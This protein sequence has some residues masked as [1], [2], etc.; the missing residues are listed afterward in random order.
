MHA[1]GAETGMEPL[2]PESDVK[3]AAE[4]HVFAVYCYSILII[5]CRADI[6]VGNAI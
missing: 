6:T 2:L 1:S 5:N 3:G 4:A